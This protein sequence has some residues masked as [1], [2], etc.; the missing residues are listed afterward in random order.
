MAYNKKVLI[1]VGLSVIALTGGFLIYK[2]FQKGSEGKITTVSEPSPRPSS[3]IES[4]LFPLR[5]G[6]YD[7][8]YVIMLQEALGV[9]A[10]GDF[11]PITYDALKSKTGKVQI[12]NYDDLM[13]TIASLKSIASAAS[14]ANR[15]LSTKLLQQYKS[16]PFG[17]SKIVIKSDTVAK[18][19]VSKPLSLDFDLTNVYV[20]ELTAGVELPLSTYQL[21]AVAKNGDL[22]IYCKSGD[23]KGYWQINPKSIEL[24]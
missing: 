20:L 7:S 4:G 3:E 12:S 24:K 17:L 21:H 9:T 15:S 16:T 13:A 6:T 14:E 8:N 22:I 19:V 1:Y 2:Y 23:N 11:G 10:D 5:K 18:E